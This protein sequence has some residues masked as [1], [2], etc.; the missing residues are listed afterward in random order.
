MRGGVVVIAVV[1]LL[2]AACGS[3]SSRLSASAYRAKI[4]QIKRQAATAETNVALGLHAQSLI[5]L[6]RRLDGF[7]V[8][9]QHIGDEVAKLKPPTNAEAAN[10]E[11]AQ[12]LHDTAVATRKASA[13][14]P[15]LRTPAEA[16]AYLEHSSLNNKGAHEVNDAFSKL[17]K[18]GYASA[19]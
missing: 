10:T 16:I 5:V 19:G 6:K 14:V 4:A 11:L 3:G 12:G 9:T 17:T 7:A 1:A 15:K 18:L 2:L 8:A 13:A